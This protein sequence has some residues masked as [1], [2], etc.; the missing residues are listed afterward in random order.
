MNNEDH[1]LL[2]EIKG[3]VKHIV[4]WSKSHD[5]SDIKRFDSMD[6][7]M[8]WAEKMLYGAVGVFVMV[9]FLTKIIK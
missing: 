2:I 3:D 4:E 9:E 5:A 1:D 8:K 6:K 7:R